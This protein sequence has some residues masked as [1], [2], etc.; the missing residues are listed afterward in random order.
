L[1]LKD[2]EKFRHG[3]LEPFQSAVYFDELFKD[4]NLHGLPAPRGRLR[5]IIPEVP[6]CH[7]LALPIV[8]FKQSPTNKGRLSASTVEVAAAFM[9]DQTSPE[10]RIGRPENERGTGVFLV[11][12][13][14]GQK[15]KTVDRGLTYDECKA[16]NVL[17]FKWIPESVATYDEIVRAECKSRREEDCTNPGCIWDE[18]QGGCL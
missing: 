15:K 8:T 9:R 1:R 11:V 5:R 18:S 3:L 10:W 16:R 7:I 13:V 14:E 6:C 4:L 12:D 17:A 2:F